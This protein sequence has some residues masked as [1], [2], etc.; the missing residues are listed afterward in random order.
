V[1]GGTVYAGGL[2]TT[3]GGQP[4]NRIAA[5]SEATGA[6]TAWNPDAVGGGV[7]DLALSGTTVYAGGFFTSIGGQ[8][9]NNIAAIDAVSGT[10][11]IWNPNADWIV[12]TLTVSGGVAYVSGSFTHIVGQFRPSFAVMTAEDLPTPALLAQFEATRTFEGTVLRWRFGDTG[13][14]TAVAVERASHGAGPWVPIAPELHHES[15]VTVAV[16]RTADG[17]G[18]YFYRLVARLADG[19][20]MVFGPVSPSPSEQVTRSDLRLASPNPTSGRIEV[21][22]GVARGGRVRL[23]LLDVSGRVVEALVDRVQAPGR[24]L[25]AWDGTGG[26]G[27]LSPGLYFV[28]LMAP[29]QMAVEK[30]AVTR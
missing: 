18:D 8:P 12:N 4:R 3:I 14:V 21:D 2:F 19:S 22:Y 6:A 30:L 17:S 13:R 28:R 7:Y 15:G 25:A 16:D 29:S 9:R 27:R 20:Q 26:R 10:A 1:S 23:D 5:L 24:Y 11:T